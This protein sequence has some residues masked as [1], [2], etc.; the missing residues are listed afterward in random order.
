MSEI[1]RAIY[2]EHR[3]QQAKKAE[4]GD[5]IDAVVDR[6]EALVR[7]ALEDQLGELR[8]DVDDLNVQLS[9]DEISEDEHEEIHHATECM[10]DG[11]GLVAKSL[12]L[13]LMDKKGWSV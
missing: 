3:E 5:M 6:V 13:K 12:D 9:H 10:A 11:V 1:S 7:K 8:S 4:S 2:H